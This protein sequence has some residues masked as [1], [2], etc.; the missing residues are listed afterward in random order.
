MRP[1]GGMKKLLGIACRS[2]HL[3]YPS[4]DPVAFC[5]EI[6]V[7]E[8]APGTYFMVCGWSRGYF[9]IQE[10]A[11]GKKLI[12][13]SVWDSAENDP[14]ATREADRVTTF[15]PAEGV[16]VKRF[17]HEG[18]GGQSFYDYDWKIGE[19]YRFCV[20]CEPN[21]PRTAYSGWFFHPEKQTWIRLM[22]FATL[23]PNRND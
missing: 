14:N 16:R 13:F 9:G 3:G 1:S 6:T 4:Q 12:L 20:S 11:N 10:L 18:S 15:G 7:R 2:V 8:S 5:N 21:G 19:T 23:T 22:T 17:G